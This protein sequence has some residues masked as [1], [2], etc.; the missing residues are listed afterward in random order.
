[1]QRAVEYA[2]FK[3]AIE[4]AV[5]TGNPLLPNLSRDE[6]GAGLRHEMVSPIGTCGSLQPVWPILYELEARDLADAGVQAELY[7]LAPSEHVND[8][9]NACSFIRA[10]DALLPGAATV[11]RMALA[12]IDKVPK[13]A[14]EV[15]SI[16]DAD[17]EREDEPP[18][19]T[20]PMPDIPG[21]KDLPSILTPLQQMARNMM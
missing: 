5:V 7:R 20:G 21:E 3:S 10:A 4:V 1:M 8:V 2:I 19:W 6:V 9:V 14:A 12:D 17:A 16:L 11:T 18:P 13:T 15:T